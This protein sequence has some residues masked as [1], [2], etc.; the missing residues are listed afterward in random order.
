MSRVGG[1][2]DL[3]R[4]QITFDALPFG[5]WGV[6]AGS[7]VTARFGRQSLSSCVSEARES[8]PRKYQR[9]RDAEHLPASHADDAAGRS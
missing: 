5:V 3:R 7:G 9:D 8:A 6:V 2:L 4:E 1:G